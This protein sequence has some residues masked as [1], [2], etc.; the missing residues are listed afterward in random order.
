MSLCTY[1]CC[2]YN[3][4]LFN[5]SQLTFSS[6]NGCCFTAG[7]SPKTENIS[8]IVYSEIILQ[9]GCG[10]AFCLRLIE[11]ILTHFENCNVM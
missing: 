5:S 9:L 4:D 8:T 1:R 7:F 10:S 6:D 3:I 11:V 2:L